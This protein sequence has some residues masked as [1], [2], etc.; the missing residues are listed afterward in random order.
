MPNSQ[1]R[2]NIFGSEYVFKADD[3]PESLKQI[4]K[5][6]DQKMREIDR[7]HSINSSLK[8][9]ILAAMN[10]A[11]E[12]FQEQKYRERL[13]EQINEES[14]KLNRSLEDVIDK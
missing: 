5:Y 6:V 13:L 8:V 2:V 11:D 7:N 14:R 9:A 12:L 4:A 3:D 1:L 10:I